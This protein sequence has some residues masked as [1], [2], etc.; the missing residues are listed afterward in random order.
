MTPQTRRWLIGLSILGFVGFPLLLAGYFSLGLWFAP[1]WPVAPAANV[2]PLVGEALWAR[3]GGGAETDLNP[4]T[5]IRLTQLAYCFAQAESEGPG[6]L[7]D[8]AQAECRKQH[9]PAFFALVYLSEQH[10]AAANMKEPG[11]RKGHAQF[12]TT[13]WLARSFTKHD[14][15]ATLV[16][17][18]EYGMG[19][20]GWET[21]ALGYFGHPTA[22]LSLAQVATL[23]AFVG[24]QGPDPWCDAAGAARVRHRILV[25]M[26]DNAAIDEPAFR[27][28]D[29]SDLSLGVP[30][31]IRP[32]CGTGR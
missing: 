28:A 20:R 25:A 23:A 22:E 14:L 5:P 6:P 13:I 17:R 32:L 3:A 26:L 19:F 8:E 18:G 16:E 2:E 7:R 30:P 9:A 21:A 12:V 10:L 4:F 31:A 11:F 1:P 15:L 27:T 24:G 29:T